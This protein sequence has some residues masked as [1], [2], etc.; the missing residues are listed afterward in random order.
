MTRRLSVV[1]ST[2]CDCQVS[3]YKY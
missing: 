3:L 2:K 1:T